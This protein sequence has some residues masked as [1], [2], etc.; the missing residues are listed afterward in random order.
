MQVVTD[1]LASG[2][3]VIGPLVTY[4]TETIEG[5]LSVHLSGETG[6]VTVAGYSN[7]GGVLLGSATALL[8]PAWN[9]VV[10]EDLDLYGGDEV[11]LVIRTP[12]AQDLTFLVDAVQYEESSPASS[13]ID[14][15]Q[16]GCAW[17]GT[18]GL[19][20]SILNAGGFT[21]LIGG[22]DTEG[23]LHTILPGEAF[24]TTL[25]GG[26]TFGGEVLTTS[27]SPVAAFD[28]FALFELTDPDPAM[29]YASWNNASQH[30]GETDYTQSYALF[31]PPLESRRR[32]S[33][34]GVRVTADLDRAARH[35]PASVEQAHPQSVAHH[36]YRR[37]A[38]QL[39]LGPETAPH[40]RVHPQRREVVGRNQLPHQQ[41]RVAAPRQIDRQRRVQQHRREDRVVIPVILVVRI[42]TQQQARNPR[43][44]GEYRRQVRRIPHRQRAQ[45]DRVEQG[46]NGGVGPDAESQREH[47][48]QREAAILGQPAQAVAQ[49]VEKPR[50]VR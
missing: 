6:T 5:S 3:G 17:L 37:C 20:A 11:Y 29:T 36:Y 34:N 31:H 22:V 12:F 28:D 23:S 16:P 38:R 32:H 30:S 45:K 49:I 9:R 40:H 19:S 35:V 39:L 1:G 2:E 15:D 4:V 47:G 46:E 42:G 10:L 27:A 8:T 33:N 48:R 14:G 25:I 41:L 26:I 24:D 44:R 7:P 43:V 13:Y 21:T 50:H 18:A